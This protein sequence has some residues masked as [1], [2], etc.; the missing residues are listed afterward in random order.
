[1]IFVQVEMLGKYAHQ[2][3]HSHKS[4]LSVPADGSHYCSGLLRL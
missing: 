1:M 2:D 4:V 3:D